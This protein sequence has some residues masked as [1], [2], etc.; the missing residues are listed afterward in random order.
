MRAPGPGT[1]VTA[2]PT[3]A[4]AVQQARNLAMDLDDR[5]GTL[6][7]LIHDRD[8]VFTTAFAEV[9]KAEGLRIITTLPAARRRWTGQT[10]P[11][12]PAGRTGT[13][14]A[15]DKRQHHPEMLPA[16]PPIPQQNRSSHSET[17]F[18]SA[19]PWYVPARHA[20]PS[21]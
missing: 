13:A 11:A 10:G 6:W 15:V 1:G 18:P 7:F 17:E 21:H 3:E 5:L 20:P 8:P 19:T 9:F 14:A 12:P 4:W 2:R 16:T